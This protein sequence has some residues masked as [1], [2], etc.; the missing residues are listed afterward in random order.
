M[1]EGSG[2]GL[3]FRRER[4]GETTTFLRCRREPPRR[5]NRGL[6]YRRGSPGRQNRGLRYRREPPGRQN[7][8]LRYRREPPGQQNRGLRYRRGPPGQQNRVCGTEESH[9]V[10][11]TWVFWAEGSLLTE[12]DGAFRPETGVPAGKGAVF[13][14]RNPQSEIR[15][16]RQRLPRRA[17][18]TRCAPAEPNDEKTTIIRLFWDNASLPN[19]PCPPCHD[20]FFTFRKK[21][22]A[23]PPATRQECKSPHGISSSQHGRI[24]PSAHPS[25]TTGKNLSARR[26]DLDAKTP[27]RYTTGMPAARRA[28][29][30]P[31]RE[32]SPR[33]AI[34]ATRQ[35]GNP[36]RI[37]SS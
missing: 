29:P 28:F 27:S 1:V 11:K 37:I 24:H 20:L 7:R 22:R 34:P 23:A 19:P 26:F 6:R 14:F 25:Y 4:K 8:G 5:Q 36:C 12:R 2:H 17:P 10:G 21:N 3:D 18:P 30:P 15:N 35:A 16:S 33:P 13:P 32:E 31:D 9:P